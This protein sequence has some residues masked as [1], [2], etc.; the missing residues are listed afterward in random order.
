MSRRTERLND[1]IKREIS[2][3]IQTEI[4]DPRVGFVTISRVDVSSDLSYADVFVSVLGSEKEMADSLIGLKHCASFLR[5]HLAKNMKT[6]TVP[7]LRFIQDRGCEH[8]EKINDLLKNIDL[9]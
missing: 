1:Q 4:R 2:E 5:T 6:R 7:K 8:S 9:E 3:S